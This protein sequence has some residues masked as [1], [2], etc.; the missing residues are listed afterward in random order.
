M[1]FSISAVSYM[2]LLQGALNKQELLR[3]KKF[4]EKSETDIITINDEITRRAMKYVEDYSLSDSMELADALI[5]A[6][7]IENDETLC[8]ANSKHYK[9]I[10][11]L[12]MQ[13]FTVE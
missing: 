6:T 2:E 7:V 3:M 9:C 4:L 5:A 11:D 12:K 8:T 13:V 1:P 10:P